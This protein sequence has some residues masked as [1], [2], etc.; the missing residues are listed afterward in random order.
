MTKKT[1]PLNNRN[2]N[3]ARIIKMIELIAQTK[4]PEQRT[5]TPNDSRNEL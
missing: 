2:N 1:L 4:K 5:E 3:N